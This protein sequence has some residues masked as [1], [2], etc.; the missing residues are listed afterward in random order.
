MQTSQPLDHGVL[1]I[2]LAKRG[3]IDAQL[4][5]Y[6]AQQAREAAV[7]R[8]AAAATTKELR[9][10]AK[11]AVAGLTA[12]QLDAIAKR[13]GST[14]VQARNELRSMAHWTPGKALVL[15]RAAL[16]RQ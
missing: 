16:N 14:R 15:A 5:A 7:A 13:I 6:K 10:A 8:K 1:N 11:A 12:D 4:D 2:P 3:D 9:A